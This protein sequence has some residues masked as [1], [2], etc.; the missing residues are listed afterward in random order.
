MVI[1][2]VRLCSAIDVIR[3]VWFA[4]QSAAKDADSAS[5]T[6]ATNNTLNCCV[7]GKILS[8]CR[9][10]AAFPAIQALAFSHLSYQSTRH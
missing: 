9:I 3:L 2:L 1:R 5:K 7:G 4:D 6:E 10:S 8:E